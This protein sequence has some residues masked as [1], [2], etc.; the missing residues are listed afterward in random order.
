MDC[1]LQYSILYVGEAMV[2]GVHELAASSVNA[3]SQQSNFRQI[4]YYIRET[5]HKCKQAKLFTKLATGI[6]KYQQVNRG[7]IHHFFYLLIAKGTY[8]LAPGKP[9][10]LTHCYRLQ[11]TCCTKRPTGNLIARIATIPRGQF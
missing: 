8:L 5:A 2:V 10:L 6:R 4:C 1:D 7:S 9:N 3:Y 11:A